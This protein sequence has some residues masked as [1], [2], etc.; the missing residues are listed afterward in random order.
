MK[1]YMNHEE[2]HL[3]F[4]YRADPILIDRTGN[5]TLGVTDPETRTIYISE[6][7]DPQ[8]K[9]RVIIHELGHCAMVS[10]GLLDDIHAM[11]YP[12]KWIEAEE[13]VCNI[14]ADYGK[15]IFEAACN[16]LDDDTLQEVAYDICSVVRR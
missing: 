10:Y 7:L 16:V 15:K 14:L 13:F 3:H 8:M 9:E 6:G 11:V 2:W 1:F 5:F 12:E 4:V